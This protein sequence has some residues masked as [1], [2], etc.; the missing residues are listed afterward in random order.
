MKQY[1]DP[2]RHVLE[3]GTHKGD[4]T[5]T[6]GVFGHRMRLDPGEG[7]PP[8]TTKKVFLRGTTREL[9]WFLAGDADIRYPCPLDAFQIGDF[10][11]TD[12]QHHPAIRAPVAA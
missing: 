3:N 5:G 10:E 12:H 11:L 2:M 8:L 7:F 1:L 6:L 4:R 9:P